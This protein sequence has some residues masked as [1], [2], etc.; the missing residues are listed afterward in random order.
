MTL[1]PASHLS[2]SASAPH[3]LSLSP[4]L[5]LQVASASLAKEQAISFYSVKQVPPAHA[6]STRER[7]A[8]TRVCTPVRLSRS[9]RIAPR[10]RAPRDRA[11]HVVPEAALAQRCRARWA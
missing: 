2:P 4:S 5:S 8:G 7:A 11:R 9:L 3:T 10:D 1:S 6:R